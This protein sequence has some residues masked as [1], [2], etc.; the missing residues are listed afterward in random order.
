MSNNVNMELCHNVVWIIDNMK[1]AKKI[2]DSRKYKKWGCLC[3]Q[4]VKY[5]GCYQ[6]IFLL[7][8]QIALP[9]PPILPILT[10]TYS[11]MYV[12]PFYSYVI[13]YVRTMS[14]GTI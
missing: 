7:K 2:R 14:K 4:P 5:L 3:I 13:K 6:D 1:V 8:R 12:C 10:I 9:A 11:R